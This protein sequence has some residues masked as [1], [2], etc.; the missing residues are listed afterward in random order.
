MLWTNMGLKQNG[1]EQCSLLEG[2]ALVYVV[3]AYTVILTQQGGAAARSFAP[4]SCG[5][6]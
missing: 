4:G 3:A 2:L 1:E 6:S 5:L